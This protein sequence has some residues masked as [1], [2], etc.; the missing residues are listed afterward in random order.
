MAGIRGVK[1]P[2]PK[3]GGK[4]TG[5]FSGRGSQKQDPTGGGFNPSMTATAM[6]MPRKKPV[7]RDN[8]IK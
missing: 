1:N 3:A 5:M 2:L 6:D 4:P 8:Q 7:K